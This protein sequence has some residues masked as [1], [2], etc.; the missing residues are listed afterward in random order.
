M[1][2]V[3]ADTAVLDRLHRSTLTFVDDKPKS[4]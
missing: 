3:V 1:S 4:L 2:S